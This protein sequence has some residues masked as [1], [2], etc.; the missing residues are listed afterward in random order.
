MNAVHHVDDVGAGLPEDDDERGGPA[1]GEADRAQVLDRQTMELPLTGRIAAGRPLEAVED[2][3]TLSLGDFAR[4]D[5][6][7]VLQV[8]GDSMIEDGMLDGDWVVIEQRNH[9]RNGEVVVALIDGGETT[10]KRIEQQPGEVLLHPAN[11]TLNTQRYRPEQVLIQGVLV[12]Q[13]RRYR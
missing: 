6:T 2:R 10:L 9:A 1:V 5:K 11:S 7:F 13:M 4:S 8:K 12:G 3:E